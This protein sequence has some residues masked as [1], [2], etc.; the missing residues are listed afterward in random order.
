[1]P[2]IDLE[3]H[4]YADRDPKTGKWRR[5]Q[6]KRAAK[7]WFFACMCIVAFCL[8]HARDVDSL[9]AASVTGMFAFFAAVFASN[10]LRDLY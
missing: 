9:T 5:P 3:P 7:W 4:E 6:S 1:M 10:W 2:E 8:W